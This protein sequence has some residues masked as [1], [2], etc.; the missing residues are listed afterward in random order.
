MVHQLDHFKDE[1]LQLA[2]SQIAKKTIP[3]YFA[4]GEGRQSEDLDRMYQIIAVSRCLWGCH[5]SK[6]FTTTKKS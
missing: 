1:L 5:S 2:D 3:G 6:K 4:V